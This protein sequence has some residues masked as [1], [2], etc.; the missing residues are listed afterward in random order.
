MEDERRRR[1]LA[2]TTAHSSRCGNDVQIV[3]IAA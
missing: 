1:L 2:E 3:C